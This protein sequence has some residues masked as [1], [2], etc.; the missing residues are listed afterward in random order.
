MIYVH[1]MI[2]IDIEKFIDKFSKWKNR[3]LDFA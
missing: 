2:N 3:K 1:P